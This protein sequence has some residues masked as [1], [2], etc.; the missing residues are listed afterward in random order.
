MN[1]LEAHFSDPE[2]F[3]DSLISL[4]LVYENKKS[5]TNIWLRKNSQFSSYNTPESVMAELE[6]RIALLSRIKPDSALI[7]ADSLWIIPFYEPKKTAI[8]LIS[9]L[10]DTYEREFFKRVQQWLSVELE[11]IL[12][13]DL[14]ASVES[15]PDLLKSKQWLDYIKKWLNSREL[16]EVRLGLN[17]LNRTLSHEY[18]NLPMIFSVLA[19]LVNK[20]QLAIQKELISVIQ[21]LIQLSEAETASFLIMT[22]EL[23]PEEETLKFL[24]KCLPLF[25]I[26]FQKEIRGVLGAH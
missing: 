17:M 16:Q 8:A 21:A 13:K 19:H 10:A 23:F 4:F 9:N 18:H 22:G 15:K 1:A 3:R 25:D 6:S 26:F 2:M 11:E 5:S 7:N 12:I 14:I 24:R 20:P